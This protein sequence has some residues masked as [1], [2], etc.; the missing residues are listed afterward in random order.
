MSL[1]FE[2]DTERHQF[3]TLVDGKKAYLDYVVLEEGE[4]LKY[5]HTFVPPELRGQGIAGELAQFA[6]NYAKDNS[7]KVNPSCPFVK[8]FIDDHPKFKELTLS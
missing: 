6:L 4:V 8:S 5:Y 3:Y 1:K 7:F 2:H